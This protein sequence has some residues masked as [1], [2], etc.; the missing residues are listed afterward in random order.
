MHNLL[1]DLLQAI[2]IILCPLQYIRRVFFGIP[3]DD[4]LQ[5]FF[6][7]LYV[8]VFSHHHRVPVKVHYP[9]L[10]RWMRSVWQRKV[11]MRLFWSIVLLNSWKDREG[12]SST[13]KGSRM[14]TSSNPSVSIACGAMY[15][16]F[17]YCEALPQAIRKALYFKSTVFRFQ[18]VSFGLILQ[19]LQQSLF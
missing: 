4:N 12:T 2:Y 15:A 10:V 14:V 18:F 17:P 11:L 1:I 6:D 13:V 8:N 9:G 19:A 3:G 5:S 7:Y 16:L